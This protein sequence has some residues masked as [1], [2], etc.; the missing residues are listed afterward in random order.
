MS[1]P[2]LRQNIYLIGDVDVQIVG[3]KLPSKLQVLK[4][5]FFH[6]HV[7][8]SKFDDSVS[9]VI[10]EVLLFW[11]KANLDTQKFQRCKQ[12]LVNL[13]GEWNTLSKHR[14]RSAEKEREFLESA[15]NLFVIAHG[16]I[17]KNASPK[18]QE[19]LIN[20]RKPNR[21]GFIA[22]VEPIYEVSTESQNSHTSQQQSQEIGELEKYIQSF[23][24][25]L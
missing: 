2:K 17:F 11:K 18:E 19:F 21:V 4:V 6:T 14:G 9:E 3:N 13:H 10:K 1:L 25:F 22:D 24:A 20:Q 12:K 7:L 15:N 16:E 5:L 23:F 8:K